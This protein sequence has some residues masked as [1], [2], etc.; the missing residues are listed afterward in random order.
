MTVVLALLGCF[1]G[2][3]VVVGLLTLLA[4]MFTDVV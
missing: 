3:V 2:V 4:A 1:V